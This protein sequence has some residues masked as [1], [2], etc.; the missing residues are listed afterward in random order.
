MPEDKFDVR[1]T[2]ESGAFRTQFVYCLLLIQLRFVADGYIGW[3]YKLKTRWCLKADFQAPSFIKINSPKYY[4]ILLWLKAH[5][6]N[7]VRL[8]NR[9]FD[10]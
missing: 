4:F 9:T 8:N 5:R 1:Y 3:Y 6:Q 10:D 7:S 2:P